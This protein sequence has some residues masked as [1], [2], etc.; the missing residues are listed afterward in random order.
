LILTDDIETVLSA[1][2]YKEDLQKAAKTFTGFRYDVQIYR[3]K[4]KKIKIGR[5]I[6]SGI[7]PPFGKIHKSFVNIQD[8]FVHIII[9]KKEK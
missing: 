9:Y 8:Q 3:K 6:K 1:E 5:I 7:V 4:G 2:I